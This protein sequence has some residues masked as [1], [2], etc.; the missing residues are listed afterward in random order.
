MQEGEHKERMQAAVAAEAEGHRALLAGDAAAAHAA[1]ARAAEDY[2][3]S[4]DVAPPGSYGRLV[5]R[6]KAAVLA[7]AA[8]DAAREVL[9]A[10]ADDPATASSPA[11]AYAQAVAALVAGDDEVARAAAGVMRGGSEA[12]GRAADGIAAVADLDEPALRAVLLAIEE[13]FAARPE[14]LSGVPIADTA[15]MLAALGERRGLGEADAGGPLRP[16]WRPR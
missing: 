6:M 15:V 8:E 14:H 2:A 7:G 3:R 5:G 16:A 10:L 4:W 11:A 9:A 12:F 13:D 1:Y